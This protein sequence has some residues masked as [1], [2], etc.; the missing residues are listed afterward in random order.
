MAAHR[1]ALVIDT[2]RNAETRSAV[3]RHALTHVLRKRK[4]VL[5]NTEVLAKDPDQTLQ[6]QSFSRPSILILCPFRS[7]ALKWF[8]ALTGP[9]ALPE[10]YSVYGRDRDRVAKAFGLPEGAV[11]K[12]TEAPLGTY[13]P[14]HVATFSGN[15]DDKFRVGLRITKRS[16][17]VIFGA[18]RHNDR[19]GSKKHNDS[20]GL[21]GCDVL[22]ASPLGLRTGIE[23]E[24]NADLLSSIEI[25]VGDGLDIMSQQNWEHVKF[26]FDHLNQMPK[27]A[28]DADFSR[29][30]SWCLDGQAGFLRQSLL[31]TAYETPELRSLYNS[32][33]KN[34]EGKC[35]LAIGPR[36]SG[37]SVPEGVNTDFM[38]F[39][40]SGAKNEPDKRFEF[41]TSQVL[42]GLLKSAVQREHACI[43]VPSSFDFIRVENHLRKEGLSVAVL[44]EYSTPQ[45]ISRA[46]QAFF[47]GKKPLL[48]V[49]ERFHFYRRYK[50]RGIRHLVFYGP[51]DHARYYAEFLSFPFLDQEVESSDV[52]ARLMYSKYDRMR[53]ERI[54]GREGAKELLA[55]R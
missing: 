32:Q 1:D 42:P 22:L 46:R 23:N 45:D 51:P 43:F 21:H 13:P 24:G 52:T 15:V 54:A 10:N 30:R 38:Y 25:L 39:D 53:L 4:R 50:L 44:S 35:R 36:E 37:V 14:D 28:R 41:F 26:V 48:L 47:T 55:G 18:Q 2:A 9:G 29:I 17:K 7:H 33:L 16:V 5:K 34:V 49:S 40:C 8:N 27:D 6:D 3:A 12:L 11:D 31:F 19:D 20:G